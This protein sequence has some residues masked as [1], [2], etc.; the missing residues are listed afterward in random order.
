M[1]ILAAYLHDLSLWRAQIYRKVIGSPYT[2]YSTSESFH[3]YIGKR[4][5][6]HVLKHIV[7]LL[8]SFPL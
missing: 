2:N 3:G 5:C 8:D 7:P 6:A 4:D 1:D